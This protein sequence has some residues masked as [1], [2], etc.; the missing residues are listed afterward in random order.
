MLGWHV[1][2]ARTWGRTSC[3]VK[4]KRLGILLQVSNACVKR[5]TELVEQSLELGQ[6]VHCAD[7]EKQKRSQ[8]KRKKKKRKRHAQPLRRKLNIIYMYLQD[9]CGR[10]MY[11]LLK[12]STLRVGMVAFALRRAT[13][14][15]VNIIG[16][17]RVPLRNN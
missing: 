4:R 6:V 14:R 9:L 2:A 5:F 1:Q 3:S 15:R 13:A 8:K 7:W 16:K 12:N 10:D 11:K 17:S